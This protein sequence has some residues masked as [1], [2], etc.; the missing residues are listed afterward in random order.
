[1]I[2]PN[3]DTLRSILRPWLGEVSN[4]NLP[5]HPED[6]DVLMRVPPGHGF[7][8]LRWQKN[9]AA[10]RWINP[11]WLTPSGVTCS[12]CQAEIQALLKSRG[13][14]PQRVRP[15]VFCRCIRLKPSRLP[16]LEFFTANWEVVLEAL[17]FFEKFAAE[18]EAKRQHERAAWSSRAVA[19][20]IPEL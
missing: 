5:S 1:M 6:I 17:S 9:N 15:Y 3:F 14:G 16:S 11:R 19:A 18:S 13:V 10:L 4:L 20:A 12:R 7:S 2:D 8:L